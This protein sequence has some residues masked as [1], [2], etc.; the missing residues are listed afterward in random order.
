MADVTKTLKVQIQ[1]VLG[2]AGKDVNK[3]TDSLK[4][5]KTNA[6][7]TSSAMDMMV[8]AVGTFAGQLAIGTVT[9][10]AGAI[11][12]LASQIVDLGT[13]TQKSISQISAMR[14]VMGDATE[15]YR[16]FNDV[17]RSTNYNADAVQQMGLQLVNLGYS[18][19]NSAELLKLC[20]DASAGLG[21]GEEG[22]RQLVDAI[23]RIQATGE[24]SSRQLIQLQMAGVNLDDA[25]KDIGMTSEEAM[26]SMQDGTLDSQKA[27]D[28]LIG[29]MH[30]FDGAMA[31]SKNNIIDMWGDVKDNISTAM[32]EIG[33]SIF[34]A[35]NQSGIIQ[36]L[37]DFT[38]DII[39][40][41]RGD[42]CGAFNDFKEVASGVLEGINDLLNIVTTTIK[43]IIVTVG[44]MYSAFRQFG[45]DVYS[46]LQ[47][48]I[49]SLSTIFGFI[50][51][52]RSAVGMGIK[53]YVDSAYRGMT[54]SR[55]SVGDFRRRENA[56][57]NNFKKLN[58]SASS[59]GGGGGGSANAISQEQKKVEALIEKYAD[60]GKI[61][62]ELTKSQ[63]ELA[64]VNL[65][66]MSEETKLTEE[67]KVKLDALNLAHETLMAGLN[68]ELEIAKQIADADTQNKVIDSI[69]AQIKAQ[70]N[71]LE[72]K[73]RQI[74]F[75]DVRKQQALRDSAFEQ[76]MQHISNLADMQKISADQRIQM[77]NDVLMKRKAQ[78][79]EMLADARLYA[80][81]RIKIES[82]L[83]ETIAQLNANASTTVKGGWLQ[84]LQ[85][86]ANQQTNFKD[87][88]V[89]IFDSISDGLTNLI[90]ATGSAKDKFKNFLR[91]VTNSILKAMTQIIVKGLI[92]KAIMNAIGMGG[93]TYDIG[94]T[95]Y[96][97]IGN[98]IGVS[99]NANGGFIKGAGT[100]KSDSIPAML[101]N[102]EY[103]LQASAVKRI[104]VP[105]LNAMNNGYASGWYVGGSTSS[106]APNVVINVENQTGQNITAKQGE[107]SFDGKSYVIGVVLE[108]LANNE[109]GMR[110][111]FKGV[112]SA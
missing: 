73:K 8:V 90:T 35:F 65:G 53:S 82:Q 43:L 49:D 57:K 51:S 48:L 93:Q 55:G 42:G 3:L 34:D 80:E 14:N 13:K 87:T 86:I 23:S 102:G 59:G 32:G 97:Q 25:F 62:R 67:K 26:K 19:Q 110:D 44:N 16:I 85:E 4:D 69:N 78:L 92:T 38:Q 29:Y 81:E 28:S 27:L 68:E 79:E 60:A 95:T 75:D 103:V 54:S 41:V 99:A 2:N 77:E 72:A 76:E 108:G 36:T 11:G 61:A 112:A 66:M 84:A 94:G 71:L 91:D 37:I 74:D 18:A 105:R 5:L 88:F 10:F 70:E 52:I 63:I 100:S 50:N 7:S 45:N 47:P 33:A 21:K 20:A 9:A 46:A 83:A 107:S 1:A 12:Q 101:S 17:A 24:M 31:Q 109:N 40:L 104:G 111:I 58:K 96:R 39:D 56:S 64:K 15:T 30:R 106:T 6:K 22:A 98:A 89:G